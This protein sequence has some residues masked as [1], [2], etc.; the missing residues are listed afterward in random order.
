[1]TPLPLSLLGLAGPELFLLLAL[2]LLYV[3]PVW[4]SVRRY[5]P[6]Q[7]HWRLF[8]ILAT[9]LLSW[10]GFILVASVRAGLAGYVEGRR[11]PGA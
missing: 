9:L 11:P 8:S 1:M 4:L 2:P 5:G 10:V 6:G 7:Q 3:L